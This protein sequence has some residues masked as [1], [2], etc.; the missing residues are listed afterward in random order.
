MKRWLALIF[1]LAGSSLIASSQQERPARSNSADGLEQLGLLWSHCH[2]IGVQSQR[3][4]AST[5]TCSP[6]GWQYVVVDEG[7]YLAHPENADK[8]DAD[9]GYVI[10]PDGL[11]LP[12]PNRFPSSAN[13][14]G[15]KA[16][17]RLRPFARPQ[18]R[19][20]HHP[21]NPQTSR[22]KGSADC[23]IVVPCIRSC[24]PDRSLPLEHRQLRS[25]GQPGR[26]GLLRFDGPAVR[27]LGRRL[28]EGGLHLA[29]LRCA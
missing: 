26:S 18:V 6:F 5:S 15:L 28:P 8:K 14:Q 22:R 13:D 7:W 29:T 17:C 2:R 16:A 21:R 10:S 9:Q 11:Y 20:S 3:Q 1:V 25:E 23:R 12:A 4:L 19:H 24:R 27:R